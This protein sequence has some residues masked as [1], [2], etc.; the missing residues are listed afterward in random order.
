MLYL[1]NILGGVWFVEENFA[2]NYFPLIASFLTKP[3]TMFGKPRNASSE[4]E[5]TEDNALLFASLKNGAYQISEYGGWSPPEDAPQNSVAIMNINGAITKYDQECGP[6]GMLTKA[7]LLNR[8]YNENNIKAIV[9]NIDSGG[10][11]GMG[12]R[13][14]QE[15]INSRNKPVVAFCNDFVASAAYGIASCCDKI[16]ANSNVCRIGSVGTYMTIVDTSEYYAKMGI[17]L[18]DIYASK[19]TDKNQEFHK[20]LQGDTEPLKKVCDTYNENFISSIANARVGVINEDQGKWAT[21]KMF[22]APEA[23]DIGMIDEI[24]TFENVLNYF[25]T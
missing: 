1:H 10:G 14:M 17:K 13:I 22:F 25:N 18:I 7:N 3:E 19:S 4:Q 24:D 5:P 11:E 9:L 23:M 21:G 6:S 20:A 15:A 16:V 12:C 8:C 2:A